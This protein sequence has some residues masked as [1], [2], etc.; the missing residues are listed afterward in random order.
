M[1]VSGKLTGYHMQV[2][3]VAFTVMSLLMIKYGLGVHMWNVPLEKV[4]PDLFYLVSIGVIL[5]PPL[6]LFAKAS[7]LLLYHRVFKPNKTGRWAIHATLALVIIYNIAIVIANLLQC[8]P[9][10]EDFDIFKRGKCITIRQSRGFS[11]AAI[12]AIVGGT[13]NSFTDLMILILPM[14]MVW[15]LHLPTKQ[16]IAV[17]GIFA[18]GAFVLRVRNLA[19]SY[20]KGDATC[21]IEAN[22]GIAC[23]C[24]PCLKPFFRQYIPKLTSKLSQ[25][26]SFSG[27]FTSSSSSSGPRSPTKHSPTVGM[28]IPRSAKSNMSSSSSSS[29]E[30]AAAMPAEKKGEEDVNWAPKEHRPG[31]D[32]RNSRRYPQPQSPLAMNTID[33]RFA[34]AGFLE[35]GEVEIEADSGSELAESRTG[36]AGGRQDGQGKV[37]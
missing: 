26:Y 19:A 1:E 5:Y 4:S 17:L 11:K 24:M 15:Q 9:R 31:E 21:I 37:R 23:G 2:M 28:G 32:A 10:K 29:D 12:I 8:T 22:V 14:P 16:K 36:S 33:T 30:S 18:T 25:Y 7:I 35:L 6:M 3:S 27:T 20:G 13:L 34:K